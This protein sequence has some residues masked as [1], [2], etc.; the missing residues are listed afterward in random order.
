MIACFSGYL[1]WNKNKA[2]LAAGMT[3]SLS[4]RFT[5]GEILQYRE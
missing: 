3:K 4:E 5:V 1:A 2:V